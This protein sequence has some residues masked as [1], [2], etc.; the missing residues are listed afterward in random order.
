MTKLKIKCLAVQDSPEALVESSAKRI[1][2]LIAP[3]NYLFTENNP[4]VLFFLTGGTERAAIKQV[5]PGHFYLLIGS[6]HDNAYSSATEV[7]AYLNEM[8][9]PAILLDEEEDV[10]KAII[11]DFFTVKKALNSLK[12]KKL[13]LI[14]QISDWLI[15]SEISSEKLEEKLGIKLIEIPW[16]KLAHFSKFKTSDS[17]I[18][19][20]SYKTNVDLTKTGQV[21]ELLKQTIKNKN[22][23]AITVEC[24]PMVKKD[25]V[26]ACL[27]LAKFNNDG[28]PA[29][30]EGDL[31]A[32]SG[33]MLCKELTGIIPWIANTNKITN[34]ICMF[35][36]CTIAPSLLS[37]FTVKTH[38]ETGV[39]TAIQGNFKNDLIT[40]FRFDKH[41]S[42][43]FI[44]TANITGR[45]K[46]NTAC[47]T[48][49]EVKLTKNEVNL[50]KNRPLGNHHLIFPGDYKKLLQ[51]ACKFMDID[52]ME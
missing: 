15:S 45:P 20:F 52:M 5:S 22:L 16:N 51:I 7:K 42:K 39:G 2:K 43:A 32:I 24:F 30:C 44:A 34:E 38:F 14:G 35:S 11:N 37:E 29:G 10:T 23:D 1:E 26:T 6:Q 28:I 4:D 48:Q 21:Y 18:K 50:L 41:L 27:P 3:E 47:R 46:S 31:T 8:N 9:I 17:F 13:G 12:E 49:I 40:I 36:H 19:T 25:S 33:M